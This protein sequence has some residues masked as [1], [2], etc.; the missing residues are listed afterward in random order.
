MRPIYEEFGI[1][2]RNL[3]IEKG[4]TQEDLA[5]KCGLD[6]T[7][8]VSIENGKA[9]PTLL[10]IATIAEVLEVKPYELLLVD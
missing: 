7:T 2:V 9:N 5:G 4:L 3:R 8:I 6:R 1:N 10:N